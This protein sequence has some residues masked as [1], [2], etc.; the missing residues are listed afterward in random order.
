VLPDE[1]LA[2]VILRNDADQ[3]T[4][5]TPIEKRLAKAG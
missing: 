1:A 5:L 2:D 4:S 3:L